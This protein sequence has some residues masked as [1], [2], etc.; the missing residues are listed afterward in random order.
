MLLIRLFRFLIGYVKFS[1]EG[2]FPER[3]M[4]LIANS[5]VRIWDNS[6]RGNKFTAT[7]VAKDYKKLRAFAKTAKLKIRID[8]KRGMPFILNKNKKRVGFFAGIAI[9]ALILFFMSSFIWRIEILGNDK[10]SDRDILN[11]LEKN[12]LKIGTIAKSVDETNLAQK[13]VLDDK[14]LSYATIFIRG[15]AV[16]VRVTE[17]DLLNEEDKTPCNIISDVSGRVVSVDVYR[18]EAKVKKGDRIVKGKLLISGVVDNTINNDFVPA[19]GDIKVKVKKSF[20]VTIPRFYPALE[21]HQKGYR[22]KSL[23]F[24]GIK[25]PLFVGRLKKSNYKI[26]NFNERIKLADAKLPIGFDTKTYH[27][28]E[29]AD[30]NLSLKDASTIANIYRFLFEVEESGKG[31]LKKTDREESDTE[32]AYILKVEYQ[33]VVSAGVKSKISKSGAKSKEN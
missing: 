27:K 18:G 8:E 12:G 1:G 31:I 24:F 16:Q 28:I 2:L 29:K 33:S 9:F 22:R 20:S 4:N 15:S 19:R 7:V 17:A 14:R 23:Y 32:G 3:F 13:L 25:I 6:K 11:L 30:K 5:D 10:I 26:Y 21:Y